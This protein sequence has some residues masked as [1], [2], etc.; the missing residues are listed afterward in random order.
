[1][2]E[3]IGTPSTTL[4]SSVSPISYGSL[5]YLVDNPSP[6]NAIHLARAGLGNGPQRYDVSG[7]G[8]QWRLVPVE[9]QPRGGSRRILVY[10]STTRQDGSY[11]RIMRECR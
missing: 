7:P 3:R 8:H 5:C 4:L 2:C 9:P 6:S 10:R 1:M 11:G